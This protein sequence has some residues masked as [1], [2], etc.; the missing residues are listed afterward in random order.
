MID[1]FHGQ[2]FWLSNFYPCEVRYD[3][4]LYRSVEHAYQAA[5]TLDKRQRNAMRLANTAALAKRLGRSATMRSDW[6]DIKLSVMRDLVTQKFSDPALGALLLAT[7][8]HDLAEGN[9]W[10]DTFWGT[11]KGTGH[12]HLGKILMDIRSAL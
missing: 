10:G 4:V 8:G 5:K 2:Y 11:C 12:N 6:S 9:W 1:N 7:K 3:G